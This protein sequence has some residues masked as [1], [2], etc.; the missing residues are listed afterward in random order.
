M[1]DS[2]KQKTIVWIEDDLDVL[3]SLI[4]YLRENG[5]VLHPSALILPADHFHPDPGDIRK[6][7]CGFID[8]LADD[9]RAG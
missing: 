7:G 3:R 9:N 2:M 5:F 8:R 6:E 1:G 4:D